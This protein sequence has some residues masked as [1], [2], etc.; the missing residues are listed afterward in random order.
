MHLIRMNPF[1]RLTLAWDRL[2]PYNAAQVLRLREPLDYSLALE[3]WRQ[4]LRDLQMGQVILRATRYRHVAAELPLAELAPDIDLDNYLSDQ[5]NS[6]FDLD[7]EGPFRAFVLPRAADRSCVLGVTYHHW[8]ADSISIRVLLREWFYRIFAIAPIADHPLPALPDG[9]EPGSVILPFA[10]ASLGEW[11]RQSRSVRCLPEAAMVDLRTSHRLLALPDGTG[12]F[13]HAAARQHGVKVGDLLLTSIARIC[14]AHLPSTDSRRPDLS[15]GTIRD[16]RCTGSP[17]DAFGASLAFATITCTRST[18]S[19]RDDLLAHIAAESARYRS[20]DAFRA[21]T[22]DHRVALAAALLLKPQRLLGLC[23]KRVPVSAGLSS[24][25]AS[26]TWL[27]Q[28]PQVCGFHRLSPAGPMLPLVITP[29]TLNDRFSLGITW[30]SALFS[31]SQISSLISDLRQEILNWT[32][33][34]ASQSY[35][36]AA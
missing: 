10:V 35:E 16:L 12:Q 18:L 27:A 4:T 36:P 32:A 3:A 30:R 25:D 2:H 7:M 9:S 33:L 1:Q 24:I 8:L 6:R 21:S 14:D 23:R 31:T 11:R 29:T 15:L 28:H 19:R 5:M 26:G 17:A 34:P 13:L 20:P 22:R